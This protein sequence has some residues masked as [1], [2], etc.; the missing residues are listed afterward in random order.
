MEHRVG[1]CH[2]GAIR[3]EVDG[4]PERVV[5]CNCSV[6]RRKGYL[7]WIVRREALRLVAGADALATYRFGTGVAQHYF[8]RVCGVAPFYVPRSHPDGYDVNVRCLDD[9]ALETLVIEPFDGAHWDEH[10]A[11]LRARTP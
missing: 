10:V 1:S 7:H 5:E 3:F 8:C 9:V 6:C 11:A 2:C 4:R